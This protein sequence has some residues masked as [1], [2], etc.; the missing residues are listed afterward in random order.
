MARKGR[1]PVVFD[2]C[3]VGARYIQI[4]IIFVRQQL[5]RLHFSKRTESLHSH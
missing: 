4:G 5:L 2:T 1:I 3:F